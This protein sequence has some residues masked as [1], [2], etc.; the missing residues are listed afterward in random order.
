VTVNVVVQVGLVAH[1][2]LSE[3]A[4]MPT[5]TEKTCGHVSA[6]NDERCGLWVR[7]TGENHG[8][9]RGMESLAVDRAV[10]QIARRLE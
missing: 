5:R 7:V 9:M 8:L 1:I 6:P 3:I 4:A 10:H 2:N